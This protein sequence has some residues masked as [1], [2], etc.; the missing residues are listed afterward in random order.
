MQVVNAFS[1]EILCALQ[2]PRPSTVLEVKRLVQATQG[3]SV[4]CQRL[5][6][7]PVGHQ[8][9][10][11]E[12]RQAEDHE[13]LATLPGLRLQLIKLEY[14]DDDEDRVGH[15][16]HAAG[17]GV[18]H[19]VEAL[20]RQPHRPSCTR[21]E[22]HATPLILASRGGHLEVVRLLCKAG[23]DKDK[24]DDRG[25]AALRWASELGHLDVA[26]LLGEAGADKDKANWRGATA[27]TWASELGHLEVLQ[28]L[29]ETGADKDKA[30]E[31]GV[32]AFMWASTFGHLEVV[33][34]LCEAG[35]DKDKANRRGSTALILAVAPSLISEEGFPKV[36]RLL[37]EAGAETGTVRTGMVSP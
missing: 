37:C 14:A 12:V 6:V 9:E 26:R 32:T 1:D 10:D 13:L 30:D 2:L 15:S 36:A 7:S 18:V 3:I 22:D 25:S 20:L 29:C 8:V 4:F 17:E 21:A 24:V 35:A 11:H 27:L 16:L 23:A 31:N 28:L 34:L 33:Q 19:E 5:L